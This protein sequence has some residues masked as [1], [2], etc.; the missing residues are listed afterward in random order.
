M[1][2][3]SSVM[4]ACC[5]ALAVTTVA[6]GCGDNA[7]L[8]EEPEPPPPP[9]PEPGPCDGELTLEQFAD[10]FNGAYVNKIVGCGLGELGAVDPDNLGAV[11]GNIYD[12][13]TLA[14]IVASIAAGRVAIDGAAAQACYTQM[15][16]LHCLAL[17]VGGDNLLS[18]CNDVLVPQVASG[19]TCGAEYEC[20]DGTC[21]G[22]EPF[23]NVGT[24]CEPTG[25]CIG[26]AAVG[27]SCNDN[28]C[29]D[30]SSCEDFDNDSNYICEAGDEGDACNDNGACDSG[31][32]CEFPP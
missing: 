27:E 32:R 10:C 23:H 16:E 12:D 4:L 3:V 13:Q 26:H 20:N 19:D 5:V 29:T 8:I 7:D 6:S 14:E 30:G 18:Q 1:K 21:V 9:P 22:L 2:R 11:I 15:T 25:T 31:L 24:V 17:F 28:Y